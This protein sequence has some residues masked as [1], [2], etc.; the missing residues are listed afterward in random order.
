MQRIQQEVSRI[1]NLPE[2]KQWLGED[3]MTVVAST[4]DEFMRFL[5]VETAKYNRVIETAG[6][7]GTL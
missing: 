4:P 1:L 5:K 6:I 7:K 2:L 3:G